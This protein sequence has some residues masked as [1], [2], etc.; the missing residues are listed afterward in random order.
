MGMST[1]SVLMREAGGTAPVLRADTFAFGVKMRERA[2]RGRCEL[3]PEGNWF[4][5]QG[6][7]S[8]GG[9]WEAG[10]KG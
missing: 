2:P 10:G 3:R 6:V 1:D 4:G 9:V 8:R 7:V 5:A